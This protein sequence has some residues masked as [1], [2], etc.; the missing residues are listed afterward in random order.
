M[1]NNT[2]V[3][4][5][6]GRFPGTL[7]GFGNKDFVNIHKRDIKKELSKQS[8]FEYCSSFG[9]IETNIVYSPIMETPTLESAIESAIICSGE[10]APNLSLLTKDNVISNRNKWLVSLEWNGARSHKHI[11][12]VL[13]YMS[14]LIDDE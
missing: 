12:N 4:V 5:F 7:G 8:I 3:A 10:S 13:N 6:Y 14:S 1:N 2:L 9:A 11:I